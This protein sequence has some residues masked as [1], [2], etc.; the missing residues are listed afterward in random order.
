MCILFRN[1]DNYKHTLFL[2]NTHTSEKLNSLDISGDVCALEY[3]PDGKTLVVGTEYK[4]IQLWDLVTY[5]QIGTLE[6]HKHAVCELAFSPDGMIL[7]SGDSGGKIHLWEYSTLSHL[8]NY[9]AHKSYIRAMSFAPDGKILASISGRGYNN[10]QDR[11][12]HLWDVP[13]K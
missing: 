7:A 3:S 8:T 10:E 2:W 12:I 4:K 5:Q 9:E 6:R 13:S 1:G 11:T